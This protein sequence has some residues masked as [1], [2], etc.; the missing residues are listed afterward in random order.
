MAFA[1]SKPPFDDICNGDIPMGKCRQR[2]YGIC[3]K[4]LRFVQGKLRKKNGRY[5]MTRN[6]SKYIVKMI[7]LRKYLGQVNIPALF[8]EYLEQVNKQN[9]LPKFSK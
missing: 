3:W 7:L 2:K 6:T 1:L 8:I 5:Q 9:D 4:M